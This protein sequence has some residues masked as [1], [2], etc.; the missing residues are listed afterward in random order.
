[1]MLNRQSQKS[2]SLW[3][4]LGGRL[5]KA[6]FSDINIQ[7]SENSSVLLGLGFQMQVISRLRN[8]RRAL[9][10]ENRPSYRGWG[11]GSIPVKHPLGLIKEPRPHN[12][13][14]P[15]PLIVNSTMLPRYCNKEKPLLCK[16]NFAVPSCTPDPRSAPSGC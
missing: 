11:G 2:R 15:L 5:R 12:Q 16:Y 14:G 1:M 13:S 9:A 8:I 6:F 3:K 7:R 10:V 4:L